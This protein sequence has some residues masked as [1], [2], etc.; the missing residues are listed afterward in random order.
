MSPKPKGSMQHVCSVCERAFAWPTALEIHFRVHTGERPF[1]C[2]VCKLRF[3]TQ[4]CVNVHSKVHSDERPFDCV[5]CTKSFK[6]NNKLNRHI[7]SHTKEKPYFCPKCPGSALSFGSN[8]GLS[9]HIAIKH[10]SKSTMKCERCPKIF[11]KAARLKNHMRVHTG[12]KPLS[13]TVC[14]KKFSGLPNLKRHSLT[15]SRKSHGNVLNVRKHLL[16]RCF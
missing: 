1:Q 4:G 7:H 16:E 9:G 10:G 8:C 3:K 15:H 11:F 14:L 5:F 6:H 2:Q 12:E 13:C